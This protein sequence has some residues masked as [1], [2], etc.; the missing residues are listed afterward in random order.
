[1][2]IMYEGKQEGAGDGIILTGTES[3][4]LHGGG[5]HRFHMR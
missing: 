2:R 1:M 5:L 4:A 3:A